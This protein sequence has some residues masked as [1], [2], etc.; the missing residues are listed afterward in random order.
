MV[1]SLRWVPTMTGI[2]SDTNCCI[3]SLSGITLFLGARSVWEMVP[4]YALCLWMRRA[5]GR[6]AWRCCWLYYGDRGSR[7][8]TS[9]A[10][11]FFDQLPKPVEGGDPVEVGVAVDCYDWKLVW[12]RV[13]V[14]PV[15]FGVKLCR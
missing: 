6:G 12:V 13:R 15:S 9:G 3:F 4:F 5:A 1:P 10:R 2:T 8:Y 11:L 14:V 7:K